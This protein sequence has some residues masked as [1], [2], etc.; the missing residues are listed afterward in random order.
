[1]N[2]LGIIPARAGSKGIRLKNLRLV[3]G[4]PLLAYSLE[5]ALAARQLHRV[6]VSTEDERIAEVA[7]RLGA[8]VPFLRPSELAGDQVS[9]IPVAR[10]AMEFYD[11]H[12]WAPD[13]VVCI[14][15]TSPLL[16]A[17]DID[18]AVELLIDQDCDA[19][20][21][22]TPIQHHHPFR[23]MKLDGN[24][25]RPLTEYTNDRYLQKQDRPPAF[26][27]TGGLYVRR[28][29]LLEQWSGQD[30]ALGQDV[31][32]LVIEPERAVNIDHELDLMVFEAILRARAGASQAVEYDQAAGGVSR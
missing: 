25:V 7:R 22:V 29:A 12:G 11:R 2:I 10:H 30:F 21:S 24:Q 13:V 32:A 31:R 8:E 26:G 17:E 15:A 3:G 18:R 28:R 20:V 6:V 19:V 14:Q 9:L 23:A 4:K 5:A 27:F 1:M 16:S